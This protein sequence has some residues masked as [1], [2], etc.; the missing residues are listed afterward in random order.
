MTAATTTP[1]MRAVLSTP[2]DDA[3]EVEKDSHVHAGTHTC[4]LS[5]IVDC[6]QKFVM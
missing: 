4:T 1:M 2:V 6:I 5:L 3:P